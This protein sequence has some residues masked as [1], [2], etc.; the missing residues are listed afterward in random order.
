MRMSELT[1]EL[2]QSLMIWQ[3][4]ANTKRIV[5][6]KLGEICDKEYVYITAMD[7]EYWIGKPIYSEQDLYNWNAPEMKRLQLMRELDNLKLAA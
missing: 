2:M 6:I 7:C 1:P 4:E 3:Q 5:T